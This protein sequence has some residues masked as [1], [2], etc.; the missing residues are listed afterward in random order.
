MPL[1]TQSTCHNTFVHKCVFMFL[2]I[3]LSVPGMACVFNP[4]D[5]QTPK[6]ENSFQD[7]V[8]IIPEMSSKSFFRFFDA[9]NINPDTSSF[10]RIHLD[11]SK[12]EA[13]TFLLTD[14]Y[15][16]CRTIRIPSGGYLVYRENSEIPAAHWGDFS[17]C[18]NEPT[19]TERL[20]RL[21]GLRCNFQDASKINVFSFSSRTRRFDSTKNIS[22]RRMR[23]FRTGLEENSLPST[24][25]SAE[26]NLDSLSGLNRYDDLTIG[27]YFNPVIPGK[28]TKSSH[29]PTYRKV[30]GQPPSSLTAK[31]LDTLVDTLT[32]RHSKFFY[33]TRRLGST[34]S[35]TTNELIAPRSPQ[36]TSL[37]LIRID[38]G[39]TA[40]PG[41]S[42]NIHVEFVMN[43]ETFANHP[44][45]RWA[46]KIPDNS[47]DIDKWTHD[48][49]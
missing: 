2:C 35:E 34:E 22:T 23:E 42:K 16:L 15:T 3:F 33:G 39:S 37:N 12:P 9:R 10:L 18:V 6:N 20:R 29:P 47:C 8:E 46:E 11:P 31:R 48:A 14:Q 45:V 32:Q 13:R 41:I 21:E 25:S 24:T 36:V 38:S 5:G 44:I 7:S 17:S 19:P 4:R 49:N 40:L 26:I 28:G 30:E 27:L 1:R 43:D